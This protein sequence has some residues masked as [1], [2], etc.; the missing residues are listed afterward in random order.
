MGHQ[1]ALG[2]HER[3]VAEWI[4]HLSRWVSYHLEEQASNSHSGFYDGDRLYISLSMC[5]RELI[6]LRRIF[7]NL[8]KCFEVDVKV[9]TVK[10]PVFEDNSSVIRAKDDSKVEAHCVTLSFFSVNTYGKE[11]SLWNMY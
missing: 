2:F 5:M 11:A 4:P 9:A 3:E 10:R 8:S 1:R 7:I 6:P